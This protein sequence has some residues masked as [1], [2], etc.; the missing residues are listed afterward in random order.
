MDQTE[1]K[2]KIPAEATVRQEELLRSQMEVLKAK[3]KVEAEHKAEA[4]KYAEYS[5]KAKKA[6]EQTLKKITEEQEKATQEL[7]DKI[8]VVQK[9]IENEMSETR[10][11]LFSKVVGAPAEA[12]LKII[13]G[14]KK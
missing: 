12:A 10:K 5:I 2:N 9:Q 6:A 7:M 11:S 13:H 8:K 4:M 14:G 3:Y 1:L